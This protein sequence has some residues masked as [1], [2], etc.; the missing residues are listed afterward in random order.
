[1]YPYTVLEEAVKKIAPRFKLTS[2]ELAD[3]YPKKIKERTEL[4][5]ILFDI[6]VGKITFDTIRYQNGLDNYGLPAQPASPPTT[7]G[8][9]FT[10]PAMLGNATPAFNVP[11]SAIPSQS[12]KTAAVPLDSPISVMR[13]LSRF[14]IMGLNRD[15]VVTLRDETRRLKL[16]KNP[17]A[18]CFLL[19]SM[20]EISAKAYCKDHQ[21]NNGPGATNPDGSD[22]RLVDVLRDIHSHLKK[23]STDKQ[24][25]RVLHGAMTQITKPEGLLSVTS[26]NQLVHNDKFTTDQTHICTVFHSIFPLLEAM[27]R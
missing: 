21:N 16:D 22:R 17:I 9:F 6:G 4:E 10:S 27:N 18:F 7:P 5:S 20:F 24:M 25:H 8:S 15:K 11:T 2:R 12:S 13:T 3:A 19:R 14:K 23:N 1:M 26:M